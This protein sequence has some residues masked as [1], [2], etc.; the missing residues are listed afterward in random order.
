MFEFAGAAAG[1]WLAGMYFVR[2]WLEVH[3]VEPLKLSGQRSP[4]TALS[5]ETDAHEDCSET[6][7]FKSGIRA[8]LELLPPAQPVD[9]SLTHPLSLAIP[10]KPTCI[11]KESA[12]ILTPP[13]EPLLLMRPS[14]FG[15]PTIAQSINR[16]QDKKSSG[17]VSDNA[18]IEEGSEGSK[19]N[20]RSSSRTRSRVPGIR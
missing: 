16:F 8:A 3:L 4:Q 14:D 1:V 13:I 18:S 5:M 11:E 9:T 20:S 12:A 19:A 7:D 17:G 6:K 10:I 2:R 15:G